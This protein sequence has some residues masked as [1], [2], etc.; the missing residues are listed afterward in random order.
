MTT[1]ELFKAR[2]VEEVGQDVARMREELE[3]KNQAQRDSKDGQLEYYRSGI[4]NA[5][6]ELIEMLQEMIDQG[7]QEDP[8]VSMEHKS[9]LDC[10][11]KRRYWDLTSE[12]GRKAKLTTETGLKKL[13]LKYREWQLGRTCDVELQADLD[14]A[15]SLQHMQRLKFDLEDLK[16]KYEE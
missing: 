13:L 7:S 9:F 16:F 5:P 10:V 12:L 14:D 4:S 1:E 2:S 3:W 15:T 6:F 8:N 11:D